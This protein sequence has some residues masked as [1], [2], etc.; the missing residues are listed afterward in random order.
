MRRLTTEIDGLDDQAARHFG[1]NRTD[2][3]V[4]DTLRGRG[5]VTP[6]ELARAVGLT[7]GGLSIALERLEELGFVR[8]SPHP[9]DRR[10]VLVEA[11]DAL[12]PLEGEV[13]GRIGKRMQNLLR[14]FDDRE[15]ETITRYLDGV[16]ALTAESIRELRERTPDTGNR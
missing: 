4:L 16:T 5:S 11:T 12:A 9:D 7:S 10:R 13:F 6:T 2:L 3:R 14:G 1:V 15:L 8:R